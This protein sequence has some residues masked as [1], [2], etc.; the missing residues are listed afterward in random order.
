M[1]PKDDP[2]ILDNGAFTAF[3]NNKPW[4]VDAFVGRLNQVETMPREPDFV[5]IPDVVTSATET[6][7]RSQQWAGI[8]DQETAFA[9]QDGMEPESAVAFADTIG[10]TT[11][12]VGGTVRWKQKVSAEFVEQAHAHGL[13]C[14]IARPNDLCWAK[15]IGAD[16]VDTSSIVQSESYDRLKRLE[17]EGDLG[18]WA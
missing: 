2:Y 3:A 1:T 12:F 11:I 14:H 15:K 9:V 18:E 17:S 8:I 5:V 6:R 16:S 10:A 7:E 4:D 13:D